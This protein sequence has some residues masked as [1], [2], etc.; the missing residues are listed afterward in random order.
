[1]YR[2]VLE[3]PGSKPTDYYYSGGPSSTTTTTTPTTKRGRRD[4]LNS[5]TGSP[6]ITRKS[7]K[8]TKGW[9]GERADI[10]TAAAVTNLTTPELSLLH[11]SPSSISILSG[12]F[13]CF[14]VVIVVVSFSTLDL[15]LTHSSIESWCPYHISYLSCY[16]LMFPEPNF[17][18]FRRTHTGPSDDGTLQQVT[19]LSVKCTL[20]DI[21]RA[22][23]MRVDD[24]GWAM[25]EAGFLA[26]S[27][28]TS[29]SSTLSLNKK[30]GR[31]DAAPGIEREDE[32]GQ[33]GEGIDGGGGGEETGSATAAA[34]EPA[35][36]SEETFFISREMV[37]RVAK[38]WGVKKM[39]MEIEYVKM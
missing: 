38:E 1:M 5:S 28:A 34:T 27:S 37:E 31:A 21:A 29:N 12:S 33:G 18:S 14:V 26:R 10:P 32:D 36:A 23:N 16:F 35:T 4:T 6:D 7:K 24:C 13:L 15:L 19:H 39:M 20:G 30:R 17:G 3:L 8:S 25:R 2:K 9:D 22:T 11:R